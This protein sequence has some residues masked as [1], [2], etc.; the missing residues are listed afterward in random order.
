MAPEAWLTILFA[1]LTVAGYLLWVLE[2]L[3]RLRVWLT[4]LA[5]V[6]F[7]TAVVFYERAD[8]TAGHDDLGVAAS[9]TAQ[10]E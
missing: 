4:V 9:P 5:V 10:T 3:P 8:T 7:A 6:S 2:L 1:V